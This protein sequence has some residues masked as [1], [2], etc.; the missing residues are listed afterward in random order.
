MATNTTTA[1]DK[2]NGSKL[3][4]FYGIDVLWVHMGANEG[5]NVRVW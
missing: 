1:N 4:W 5:E 3:L 2:R